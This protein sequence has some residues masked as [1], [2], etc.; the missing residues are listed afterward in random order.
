M[1]LSTHQQNV[2]IGTL[3]GDGHLERDGRYVR[4]KIDHAWSQAAYVWWKFE[5]FRELTLRD[6]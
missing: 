3:L 5:I 1:E 2:L 6:P 4:L